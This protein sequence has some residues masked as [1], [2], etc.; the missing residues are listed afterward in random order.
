MDF[1][2]KQ[3]CVLLII[4]ITFVLIIG[5]IKS[6]FGNNLNELLKEKYNSCNNNGSFEREVP[7]GKV[8][9]NYLTLTPPEKNELLRK[10]VDNGLKK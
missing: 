2:V 1:N 10:F 9:G 3:W 7:E 6:N 4:L 5:K 8:P